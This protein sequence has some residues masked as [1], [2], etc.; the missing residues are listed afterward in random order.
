MATVVFLSAPAYGHINPTLPLTAEL[1]RRGERV[2]YYALEEFQPVIER[3]GA[4][5]R[6]YGQDFPIARRNI[7][8]IN[9]PFLLIEIVLESSKWLLDHHLSEI[10]AL[11]PDYIIHDAFAYWGKCMAEALDV[12]AISSNATIAFNRK[13]TAAGPLE[14]FGVIGMLWSGREQF[15]HSRRLMRGLTQTYQ[16]KAPRILFEVIRTYSSLNIVYTSRLF[17][18]FAETFDEKL[19]KFVGPSQFQRED[20]PPFPLEQLGKQPLI[21]I[22][23]GTVYND[24]AAFF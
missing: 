15:Q 8:T 22:S 6:S 18:P 7:S 13:I 21:Y 23:L 2:V 19:F 1:V 4:I 24:R 5:F 14:L 12:P 20:A 17:Q 11:H 3:T 10:R 16:I 9:N